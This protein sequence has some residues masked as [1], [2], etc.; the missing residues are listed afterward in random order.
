[1]YNQYFGLAEA[2]FSIAPDPRYLFLSEQHR[3]ALAHLLYGIG[4]QGG[5]VVLT[6]EVGTGKTT[7]CRCLL[8]QLPEHA[9]V[10]FIVNPKLDSRELLQSIC[11]ELGVGL[12]EGDLTIKQLIDALNDFLLQTHARG[13]NAILI[14]DEAQN[15][16]VA[17]LEQLRLLTNL[18]TSERKLLQLILLGQPELNTLLARP[19][20]RQ[21]AQRITARFHLSPLSREE[22]VLYIQHRLAIAGCRG[23]LFGPAAIQRIFRYSQGIPR[24]INLL[25]DRA[26]LGVYA[27]NGRAVDTAMV[28]RAAHEVLPATAS[29]QRWLTPRNIVQGAA[30]AA[31]ALVLFAIVALFLHRPAP[32]V[33]ATQAQGAAASWISTLDTDAN[34]EAAALTAVYRHSGREIVDGAVPN[35]VIEQGCLQLQQQTLDDLKR[36]NRPLALVIGVG[37]SPRALALLQITGSDVLVKFSGRDWTLPWSELAGHWQGVV[38]LPLP[39]PAEHLPLQPG[40]RDIL[41]GWL[42][43]Q[44]YRRYHQNRLRWVASTVDDSARLGDVA[45]KAAWLTSFYLGL[46]PAPRQAVFD[47][48]LVEEVKRFQ[49]SENLRGDGVVDLAT[50]L[51]LDSNSAGVRL[52]TPVSAATKP[53]VNQAPSAIGVSGE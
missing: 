37:V 15:L 5:F 47:G 25:C 39:A 32:P 44:L 30:I 51:A 48:P 10:A 1:M 26:L 4:D 36:Y 46:H 27:G 16:D 18:E 40:T 21:L 8:Q 3:E 7:V 41:A 45:P 53:V 2:P 33:A 34:S 35:C 50:I 19:D 24:L 14:I 17:V 52:V 20:L 9:D 12:P 49:K 38:L 11:E 22:V 29:W 28:A 43:E 42:D 23:E 31:G 6:G 13:R